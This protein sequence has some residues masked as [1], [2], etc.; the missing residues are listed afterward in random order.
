[1][2]LFA[3]V[4][5]YRRTT[6]PIKVDLGIV[7]RDTDLVIR[8]IYMGGNIKEVYRPLNSFASMSN[9]RWYLYNP[10]LL[11]VTHQEVH[12]YLIRGRIRSHVA[13]PNTEH[14]TEDI[15]PVYLDIMKMPG[16][17]DPIKHQRM[18]ALTETFCEKIIGA[19]YNFTKKTSVI[20]VRGQFF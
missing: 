20:I 15:P 1:V 11:Q 14:T 8:V 4:L 10:R 5:L 2:S 12:G 18:A 17:D 6:D 19:A 7:V 3:V 9:T 13:K 16:F